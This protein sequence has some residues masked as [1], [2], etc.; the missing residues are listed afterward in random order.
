[1]R[2]CTL[3]IIMLLSSFA[4]LA[5][6]SWGELSQQQRRRV[7]NSRRVVDEVRDIVGGRLDISTLDAEQRSEILSCV[8]AKC[9]DNNTAALFLYVYD[10][11]RESSGA[12][13]HL[14]VRMLTLHTERILSTWASAGDNHSLVNYAYSLGCCRARLGKSMIGSAMNKLGKK[15]YLKQY[16]DVVA[17]FHRAVETVA[18]SQSVGCRAFEDVTPPVQA[19]D[20]LL[21]LDKS[22]FEAMVPTISPLVERLGSAASDVEQALRRECISWSGAYHTVIKHSI[23]RNLQLVRST[24]FDAEYLT[25]IDCN[26]DS[27]TVENE[28]YLLPENRF[29]VIERGNK[30][31]SLLLGSI[32]SR[33]GVEIVGRVFVDLGRELCEVKCGDGTLYLRVDGERGEEYLQLP[34]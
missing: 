17:M 33:G 7:L 15:R 16:G 13:G 23:N 29:V 18:Q 11:L 19:E 1:M 14:D 26:N 3:L 5:Q 12:N 30:P 9:G 8:T 34:L 24:T 27:Y 6:T 28:L 31:Q 32:T 20:R 21:L 25:L 4:A 2:R 10:M 22:E